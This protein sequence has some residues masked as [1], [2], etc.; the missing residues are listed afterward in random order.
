M[1]KLNTKTVIKMMV[2]FYY[3]HTEYVIPPL[4]VLT[5]NHHAAFSQFQ[6]DMTK[7]GILPSIIKDVCIAVIVNFDPSEVTITYNSAIQAH[8]TN[9]SSPKHN[10]FNTN[11]DGQRLDR[12]SACHQITVFTPFETD[13]CQPCRKAKNIWNSMILDWYQNNM[14]EY[15]MDYEIFK[16]NPYKVF[17]DYQIHRSI[18]EP[19]Y[20]GTADQI[21][22]NELIEIAKTWPIDSTSHLN[23]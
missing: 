9:R 2:D 4:Q 11:P 22:F 15:P 6:K 5:T 19:G 20:I 13:Y 21:R 3:I 14:K 10:N 8:L 7:A 18:K 12:C 17:H 1:A 16:V 23:L